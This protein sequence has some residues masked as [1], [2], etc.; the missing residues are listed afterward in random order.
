MSGRETRINPNG[1]RDVIMNGLNNPMSL[2]IIGSQIYVSQMSSPAG[3]TL[4]TGGVVVSDLP[5]N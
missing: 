1:T 5:E 4:G 3:G 2:A